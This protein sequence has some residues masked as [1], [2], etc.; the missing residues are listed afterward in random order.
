MISKM[1]DFG[2]GAVR[3]TVAAAAE[4]PVVAAIEAPLSALDGLVEGLEKAGARLS[5]DD[6][7]DVWRDR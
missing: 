3:K 1:F 6:G 7:R 5:G 4:L 2:L